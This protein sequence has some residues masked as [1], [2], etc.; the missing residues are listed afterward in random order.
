[1][2]IK[3]KDEISAQDGNTR[4]AF[5]ERGTALPTGDRVLRPMKIALEVLRV[6][7]VLIL[8]TLFIAFT[9]ATPYFFTV[10]NFQNL[11][12]QCAIV[13]ALALGE[14]LVIVVRGID[15]SVASTIALSTVVVSRLQIAG[16]SSG[17]VDLAAFLA[18]GATMGAG[19]ALLIVKGRIPQPLVATVAMAGIGSGL[20]LLVSGG[21][22]QVGMGVLV[23]QAGGGFL[24][25]LPIP[26]L[27][28]LLLAAVLTVFTR[29][30]QWGRWIYAVGGN[31]EAASWLGVPRSKVVM[32][33]Y[34][35]CGVLAGVGGLI[36]AGRSNASSPL[37]GLGLEMDAITA[38]IIGGASM[39]GGRGSVG[40]VLLGALIIG[41]IR[42][43][44]DLIGVSVFWQSISVG[45]TIILALE[46]DVL[47]RMLETKV[48]VRLATLEQ[49]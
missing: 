25:P 6:G 40:N 5:T 27:I 10:R 37:A 7:P 48:R 38:V 41:S 11:G 31:P 19:N 39:F 21:M 49:V 45:V 16:I 3:A 13:S 4:A 18:V 23:Q 9:I 44:L 36:Y 1:M 28:I 8:G 35:L 34:I 30:T 14:F 42:N 47:R 43:G 32:S 33:A 15:V 2:E 20:A 24:G 26:V 29:R 12:T 22:E 46:L 17:L